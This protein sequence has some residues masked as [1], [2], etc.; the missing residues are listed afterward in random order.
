MSTEEAPKPPIKGFTL[1]TDYQRM[2]ELI[3]DGYRVPAW[4][5]Y[6]PKLAGGFHWDIVEVKRWPDSMYMIGHRG[7]GYEGFRDTIEDFCTVCEKIALH[8]IMPSAELEA[9]NAGD[10]KQ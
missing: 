8:Y 4:I 9:Q 1:S 2:W 6:G 10:T 3:N 5:I 7:C